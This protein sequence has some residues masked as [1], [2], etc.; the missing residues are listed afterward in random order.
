MRR[1]KRQSEN[2]AGF[3]CIAG[4]KRYEPFRP[5]PIGSGAFVAYGAEPVGGAAPASVR[6]VLVDR[7]SKHRDQMRCDNMAVNA[8]SRIG[9]LLTALEP[10]H[11]YLHHHAQL[12][13]RRTVEAVSS[14]VEVLAADV[15]QH[16]GLLN[17]RT[18][19]PFDSVL[20]RLP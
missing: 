6:E 1:G 11:C 19:T 14:L 12:K 5:G 3:K 4:S 2:Q 13:R 17:L 10:L 18:R 16:L 9:V 20:E 15:S 7:G 8:H